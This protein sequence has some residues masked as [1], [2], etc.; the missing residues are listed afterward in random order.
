MHGLILG[1]RPDIAT[2]PQLLVTLAALPVATLVGWL[3]YKVIEEP[4]MHY[5]MRWTWSRDAKSGTPA[6]SPKG[7]ALAS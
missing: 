3:L 2:L 6:P 1:T 5:A 4:C 7:S